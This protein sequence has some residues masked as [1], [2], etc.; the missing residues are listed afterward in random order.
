MVI[1]LLVP[2]LFVQGARR[3]NMEEVY[4]RKNFNASAFKHPIWPYLV[5]L[6]SVITFGVL[7]YGLIKGG[8]GH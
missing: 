1:L 7:V 4:D 8:G 6:F 5:Y 3:L 2:A